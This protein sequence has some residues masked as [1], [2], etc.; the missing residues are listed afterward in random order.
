MPSSFTFASNFEINLEVIT[1]NGLPFLHSSVAHGR[2][3]LLFPRCPQLCPEPLGEGFVQV[4]V[5]TCTPNPQVTGHEDQVL[6]SV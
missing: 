3:S 2:A 4:R 1:C 5:L 6:Q